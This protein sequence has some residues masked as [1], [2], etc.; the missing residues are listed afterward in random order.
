[1]KGVNMAKKKLTGLRKL[2]ADVLEASED[3]NHADHD[4]YE[5]VTSCLWRER[6]G[7]ERADWYSLEEFKKFLFDNHIVLNQVSTQREYDDDEYSDH[8]SIVYRF[9]DKKEECFVAFCGWVS[10]D[11]SCSE[12]SDW[13]FVKPVEKTITVYEKE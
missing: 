8:L 6:W 10:S 13:Y 9:A 4:K 5:E 1:M 2:V 3:W 11:A 7:T 12:M